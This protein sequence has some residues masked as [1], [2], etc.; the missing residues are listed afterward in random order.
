[1]FGGSMDS[2]TEANIKNNNNNNSSNSMQ[3]SQLFKIHVRLSIIKR[4]HNNFII[5]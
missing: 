5:D 2:M 4:N 3:I 1:M